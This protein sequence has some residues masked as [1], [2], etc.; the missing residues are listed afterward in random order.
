M[1]QAVGIL[2]ITFVAGSDLSAKQ[3]CLV[4]LA[5]SG[6]PMGVILPT[7]DGI[8]DVVIGVLQNKPKESEA[9]VV[10]VA[11]TSKVIVDA[12]LTTIG[13][14]VGVGTPAGYAT[15]ANTDKDIYIGI[16]L[17][18]ASAAGDIVEVLLTGPVKAS[19]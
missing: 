2:D 15:I 9:A 1:S 18:T 14:L 3:Y 12:S 13:S 16:L 5:G 4:K 6:T 8:T 7:A 19:I 17:E 10:R 11:G